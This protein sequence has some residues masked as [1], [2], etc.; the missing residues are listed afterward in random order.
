ML[1]IK[2]NHTASSEIWLTILLS[3]N[4]NRFV[5]PGLSTVI[6]IISINKIQA[7]IKATYFI[8]LSIITT[9]SA[10]Y[11]KLKINVW[12]ASCRRKYETK[13]PESNRYECSHCR[14]YS[15]IWTWPYYPLRWLNFFSNFRQHR[16]RK[17]IHPVF[18]I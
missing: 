6:L 2:S 9:V 12:Q 10:T 15:P 13:C 11:N 8:I 16:T 1:F 5:Q 7:T 14:N 18:P 17:Q 4:A 3:R